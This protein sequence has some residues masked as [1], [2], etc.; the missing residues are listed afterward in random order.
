MSLF[1]AGRIVQ[2]RAG[3]PA[4]PAKESRHGR[5]TV[6]TGRTQST[7]TTAAEI[8]NRAADIAKS[9]EVCEPQRVHHINRSPGRAQGR[10]ARHG[11]TINTSSRLA[12]E[13]WMQIS[14]KSPS[15]GRSAT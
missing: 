6:R 11:R 2:P 4:E 5:R 15:A 10:P 8:P 3:G 14:D 1:I 7:E 13:S 12:A 9:D